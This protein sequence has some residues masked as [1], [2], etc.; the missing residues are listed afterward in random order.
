MGKYVEAYNWLL[1]A[2]SSTLLSFVWL[3]LVWT[4]SF[5][6]SGMVMTTMALVKASLKE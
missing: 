4:L 6:I 5:F 1:I 2:I 3:S